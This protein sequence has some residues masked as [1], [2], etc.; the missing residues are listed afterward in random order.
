M[1]NTGFLRRANIQVVSIQGGSETA[2]G[3]KSL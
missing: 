2:E 1:G 3:V